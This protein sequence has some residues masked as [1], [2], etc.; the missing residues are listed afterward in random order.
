MFRQTVLGDGYVVPARRDVQLGHYAGRLTGRR[1]GA[2]EDGDDPGAA[3]DPQ[4]VAGVQHSGSDP[5]GNHRGSRYSRDTMA[6]W[7][8]IPPPSETAAAIRAKT[9]DQLGA[10]SG[11][12]RIS[13]SASWSSSST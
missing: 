10:V 1:P 12:T 3:V 13:P 8:M 6:A 7:D 5:G 2:L 11:Q 4:P 9:I